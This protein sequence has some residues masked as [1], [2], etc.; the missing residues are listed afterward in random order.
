LDC[1]LIVHSLLQPLEDRLYTLVV[2]LDLLLQPSDLLA[3]LIIA[4]IALLLQKLA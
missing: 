1:S 3:D 2:L 4:V